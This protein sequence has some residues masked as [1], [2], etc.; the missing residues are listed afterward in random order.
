M[1]RRSKAGS[2]Q[3]R[4]GG[5][6]FDNVECHDGSTMNKGE[7]H[8]SR[9]T[10][11][12]GAYSTDRNQNSTSTFPMISQLQNGGGAAHAVARPSGNPFIGSGTHLR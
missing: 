3:T 12:P 5:A 8:R 10:G 1:W 9:R 4:C 6:P 2:S 11:A 7:V